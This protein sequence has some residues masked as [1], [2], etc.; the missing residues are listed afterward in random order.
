MYLCVGREAKR[1]GFEQVYN[2]FVRELAWSQIHT[3]IS[4]NDKELYF[5]LT[6]LSYSG[7]FPICHGTEVRK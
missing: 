5:L 7:I 1:T 2:Y 6:L 4:L 3:N